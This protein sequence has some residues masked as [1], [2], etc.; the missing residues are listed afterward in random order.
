M[1]RLKPNHIKRLGIDSFTHKDL[2]AQKIEATLEQGR[3]FDMTGDV[4]F[5]MDPK[6]REAIHK[7]MTN[8]EIIEFGVENFLNK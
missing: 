6:L 2:D 1:K 8:E 3:I 4:L 5:H 7:K